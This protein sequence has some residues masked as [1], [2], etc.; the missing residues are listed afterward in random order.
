MRKEESA[1][2][3][4]ST[5]K[6][7][8]AVLVDVLRLPATER[9]VSQSLATAG[10][11]HVLFSRI[12]C[13]QVSLDKLLDCDWQTRATCILCALKDDQTRQ[14]G[15]GQ[16]LRI[17]ANQR[18][19][20]EAKRAV[21]RSVSPEVDANFAAWRGCRGFT[22]LLEPVQ[23]SAFAKVGTHDKLEADVG[24]RRLGSKSGCR[25]SL[26]CTSA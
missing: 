20:D 21:E 19:I 2:R 12:G 6:V 22:D 7:Q 18:F 25:C 11:I 10:Q 24:V 3:P 4:L 23:A 13:L 17:V 26:R 15:S 16:P 14:L 5:R 9:V 8:A 1:Q